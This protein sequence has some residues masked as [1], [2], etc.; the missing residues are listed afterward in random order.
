MLLLMSDN[1]KTTVGAHG[2]L[3]EIC[4]DL[5]ACIH[6][7]YESFQKRDEKVAEQFREVVQTALVN[8]P[9][10]DDEELEKEN[11]EM[12]KS[13]ED[14]DAILSTLKKFVEKM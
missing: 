3:V 7:M 9:F 13:V 5:C 11:T 4:S 14:L 12:H 6:G 1:G 2:D 8:L 10:M